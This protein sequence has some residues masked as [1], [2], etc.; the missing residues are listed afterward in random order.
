MINIIIREEE[1][2]DLKEVKEMIKKSFES[3]EHTDNN[4]HNLAEKLRKSGNFI[5]ELSLVAERDGKIIGHIMSTRLD[6]VSDSDKHVSLAIA[7]LSVHPDFQRMGVGG[8]LIKETFKIAK[9]LGYGSIFL[10]GSEKYYPKF[11]FEKSTNFG[12][13]A[14]FDVP[15][16]NFMAIEL[17]KGALENVSG[18]IVYA[19]EFFEA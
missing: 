3:A 17:T 9:E 11:G 10:L 16:E 12:I 13:S 18:N 6:I 8:L 4:E 15:S 14:P 1:Q 5:K 2:K 7:P 19:K